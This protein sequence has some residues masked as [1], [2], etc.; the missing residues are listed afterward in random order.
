MDAKRQGEPIALGPSIDELAETAFNA[1]NEVAPAWRT[2]D[3]RPVPRWSEISEAVREKW[4]AA[5]RALAGAL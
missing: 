5:A 2:F 4:R 3:G 1:Y